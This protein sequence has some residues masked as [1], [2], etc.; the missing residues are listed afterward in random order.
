L[1]EQGATPEEA[2]AILLR[3]DPEPDKRQVGMVGLKG[4]SITYTGKSCVPW[5]WGR[6]GV[7]YAIQGNI[8]TGEDVVTAMETTFLHTG[9]TLADRLF[10]ALRA[11]DSKGGD[12]RGRQSAALLVVKKNAG[13]GG[14]TDRAVDIR[15]D[16]HP[17]PFKELGRLLDYAQMNYAWNEGWTMFTLHRP[18]EALPHL[19]RALALAPENPEVL[20]DLAVIRLAAGLQQEALDALAKAIALNPKLRVQATA[21]GDLQALK[22]NPRFDALVKPQER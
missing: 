3:S 16:D 14:F 5:A 8:L 21:D 1:L 22:G 17:D 15:V 13:Y 10:A 2:L 18:Q 4:K 12:S 19:D 9:G 6:Q 20:Y 7:N 11:G